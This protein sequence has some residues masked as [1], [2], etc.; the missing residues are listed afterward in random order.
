MLENIVLSLLGLAL[1][2]SL[3][4]CIVLLVRQRSRLQNCKLENDGHKASLETQSTD[5]A[6]KKRGLEQLQETGQ[7]K[8][9]LHT[10]RSAQKASLVAFAIFWFTIL[11]FA[12]RVS[13][14]G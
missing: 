7:A 10:R 6:T 9:H 1:L 8:A 3:M 11:V 14:A 4:I 12:W 13:H 5:L 2:L